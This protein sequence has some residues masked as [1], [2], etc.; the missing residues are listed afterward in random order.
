MGHS[1]PP[2]HFIVSVES[3]ENQGHP[4]KHSATISCTKT[5]AEHSMKEETGLFP[6]IL[7]EECI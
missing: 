2:F 1:A 4:V 3:I 5:R 6:K 7:Q